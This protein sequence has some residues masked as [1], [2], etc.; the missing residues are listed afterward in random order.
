VLL[1]ASATKQL[2]ESFPRAA[3]QVS[4]VSKPS[5]NDLFV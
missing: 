2:K 5:A 1:Y 3:Q 4:E